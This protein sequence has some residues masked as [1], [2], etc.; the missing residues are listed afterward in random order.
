MNA[1]WICPAVTP[2]QPNENPSAPLEIDF[3]SAG[4]LYENLIANDI[5]GVLIGGSLGEFFGQ[6]L[7]QREEL[8]KFA[9]KQIAGRMQVIIGTANMIAE[10]IAPLS[11]ACLD[12]GAD[13]VMIVP[14]F[15]F[16]FSD[17][18]MYDFYSRMA[19]EI[20]GPVYLYNFPDRTG[21]TISPIVVRRL[22][23]EYENI[24]GIKDTISGM[25]HTRELIKAV[26][27][28][29]PDFEI[30]SGFD[31]N[32]AHNVLSGGDGA[33][34]GFSN[35]AP[36]I[37]T[38]WVKAVRANDLELS[39]VYHQKINRCMDVYSI[40]APFVPYVK[41]ACRQCG[42]IS[43]AACTFPIP[44]LDAAER[45]KVTAFLVREGLIEATS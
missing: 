36:K 35:V 39:A 44:N 2:F 21:Y 16:S 42:W 13:A 27:P 33:I 9:V 20:H 40:G 8:A 17:K 25:D 34:C 14:P 28:I 32:F 19:K 37:C 22:S 41:E 18:E 43:S 7:K 23:E 30:F 5:D 26:K 24:V 10:E 11:N 1:K 4:R 29:R 12:A 15:Y 38:D 3:E 45:A 31:D 6:T